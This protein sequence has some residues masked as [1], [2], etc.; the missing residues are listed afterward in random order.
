[1]ARLSVLMPVYNEL[2]TIERAIDATLSA[3]LPIDREIVIVDDGSIDGTREILTGRDWP[4]EIRVILHDQNQGKGAAVRT[5][6]AAASG[7]YSAIFDADLEY[8]PNDLGDLLEPLLAG[9]ANVAFGVRA[10]DGASSHSFL[11]VLGNRGVTLACDVLFNVFLH[12][13]M[14]CHKVIRTE[15]FQSLQ[16]RETGFAI[17]PEI[18]ARLI[19]RGERIY[20]LPCSYLARPTSAGKKLNSIDGFRVLRTLLRLRL[21][22]GGRP[23]KDA[24][25]INPA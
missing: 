3:D 17:E 9:R 24:P 13:I 1:M 8:D 14:T 21:T 5:A 2:A 18:T 25:V 16:L 4:A 22:G 20:E 7:E 19:Q 11:Y 6:L 12:D 15:V 10:F 23:A